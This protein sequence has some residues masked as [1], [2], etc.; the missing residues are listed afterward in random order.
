VPT[1]WGRYEHRSAEK[2]DVATSHD[3]LSAKRAFDFYLGLSKVPHFLTDR[4]KACLL[5]LFLNPAGMGCAQI[6]RELQVAKPVVTR[7][8]KNL[9]NARIGL[10]TS[11]KCESDR[12]LVLIKLTRSGRKFARQLI[13]LWETP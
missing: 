12:R 8:T 10:I 5:A 11:T 13:R 4:E 3:R 2:M 7:M 6:A 9:Q 1:A